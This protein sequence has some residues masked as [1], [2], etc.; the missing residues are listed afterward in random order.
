MTATASTI[1]RL[2]DRK[3]LS[4]VVAIAGKD[5][6]LYFNAATPQ[7]VIAKVQVKGLAKKESLVALD[8]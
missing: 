8:F 5:T 3:L 4:T 2:E 7:T 6:L 1:E